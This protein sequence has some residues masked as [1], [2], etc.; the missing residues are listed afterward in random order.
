MSA[1]E[2]RQGGG[3][4]LHDNE[5]DDAHGEGQG[6]GGRGGQRQPQQEDSERRTNKVLAT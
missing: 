5:A 6:A 2:K 1:I 4:P 3:R